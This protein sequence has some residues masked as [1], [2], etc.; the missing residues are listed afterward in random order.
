MKR[1]WVNG[2]FDILHVGHIRLLKYASSLGH[3]KVGLDSDNR[4]SSRKGLDRPINKLEDR[5]EMI[6][7]LKYVNEISTF[8]SEI[9]LKNLIREW[10]P[11]IMVVGDD[12]IDKTVY[13]K[14]FV[15]EIIFF[16]KIP[17]YST[18]NILKKL[19][20]D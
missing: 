18:T 10:E 5:I 17:N 6:E 16:E 13:G 12:Y 4:I 7:S 3:L 19:R 11:D 8:D 2:S 14:E 20:N 15:N 1:V 9:E